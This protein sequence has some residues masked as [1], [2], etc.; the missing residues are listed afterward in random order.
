MTKSLVIVESPAKARTISKILGQGYIVKPTG[1]HIIDLPVDEFGIDIENGFVPQ[2]Q[3]IKGKYNILK[4]MKKTAKQVD[5]VLLATDPDREGEAIAWHVANSVVRKDQLSYRVLINQITRD[6]VLNA[7]KN[8]GKLDL[9]KVDA[10]QARR[11]LDRIVGYQVSPILWKTVYKG[12]SAGRVQSVALRLI[13]ERDEEIMSFVPEEFWAVRVLLSTQKDEEFETRL[14]KKK[15]KAIKIKNSEE[16]ETVKKELEHISFRVQDVSKKKTKKLPYPPFITSTLQQEAARRLRFT[17]SRTMS[18]AQSLYDGVELEGVY[19]GLITYMRTDSTRIASEAIDEV[20]SYIAEKWGENH[21]PKKPNLYRT[22][23][24]AQ[25]AHE[26]IRPASL[27]R[28]PEKVK[29]FLSSEQ[30]KLYSVIWK[31]FVASQMKPAESTV[32]IVDIAAGQYELR[33]TATH[34]DYKG[35]LAVYEDIKQ[36]NDDE[37]APL[38]KLP[39]LARGDKLNHKK[40]ILSQKYTQPPY[41]Y[42]DATLVKELE[43]QG[44][45]RP[46][47]YAQII[48]TIQTRKY[49]NRDK[50][51]L[52]ATDLGKSVNMILVSHFPDVFSVGFTANMEEELDKVETGEYEWGNVVNEFFGPFSKSLEQL[53]Q[54]SSE[55]KKSMIEVTEECCE[56]CGKTMVIR[57]GRNGRFMACSGFPKCRNTKSLEEESKSETTGEVCDKCG[58]PMEI[59]T[60]KYGRFFAC[61]N[62]PKCKNIKPYALGVKCPVE[63]C[64]GEIVEKRSKKGKLFYS[65]KRYPDCKFASWN[66]LVAI[67][68]PTCN[69]PSL[70]E[71]KNGE[72][73]LC[74][75]CKS[76]FDNQTL[77]K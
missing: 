50:G 23:K 55:V 12:L 18:I 67:A 49:V 28:P 37:E 47:T 73:Y 44:I 45:G 17:V 39:V 41:H 2:Y 19:A 58:S 20:R 63:G 74:P 52:K 1:G 71:Y 8:K 30:F 59:K 34:L 31:R 38:A 43:T 46:S 65:C 51:K 32:V 57:W 33:S 61:S 14:V 5:T 9:K 7:V 13:V 40:T 11:I 3:T 22:K 4:E 42:S 10:Q 72:S 29:P 77:G 66:K 54:R 6:A 15:G 60:G 70:V 56:K 62:Y 24:G 25:D 69:S 35:F 21:I 16:A 68:C 36:D 76:R 27:S 26:A 53:K 64:D 48:N 75:R